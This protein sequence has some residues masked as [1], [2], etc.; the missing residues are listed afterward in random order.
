MY[1]GNSNFLKWWPISLPTQNDTVGNT[2]NLTYVIVIICKVGMNDGF[3]NRQC[4][5]SLKSSMSGT[6]NGRP[7]FVSKFA[8]KFAGIRPRQKPHVNFNDNL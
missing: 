4:D 7:N 1:L 3:H 8:H 6:E 2:E 5:H